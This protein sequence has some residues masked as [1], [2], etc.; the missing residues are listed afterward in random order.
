MWRFWN[1][2]SASSTRIIRGIRCGSTNLPWG[3]H[4][5]SVRRYRITE[6]E[7]FDPTGEASGRGTTFTVSNP[8]PPPGIELIVLEQK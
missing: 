6:K 3:D 2:G 5:F 1:L 7:N 8:L 4:E